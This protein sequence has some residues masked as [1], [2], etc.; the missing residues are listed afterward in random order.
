MTMGQRNFFKVI[1]LSE[2]PRLLL[3]SITAYW[4]MSAKAQIQTGECP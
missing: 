3:I 2:M 4:S 1:V